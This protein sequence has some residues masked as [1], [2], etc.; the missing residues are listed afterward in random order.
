M[1]T[2][3][4]YFLLRINCAK[5]KSP[6][7]GQIEIKLRVLQVLNT[8]LCARSGAGWLIHIHPA[9]TGSSCSLLRQ[10]SLTTSYSISPGHIT[11]LHRTV[12]H[13]GGIVRRQQQAERPRGVVP[14]RRGAAH[15]PTLLPR[16]RPPR[17]G[18]VHHLQQLAGQRVDI[19]RAA[20]CRGKAGDDRCSCS[21]RRRRRRLRCPCRAYA[22][23]RGT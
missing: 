7:S 22:R 14:P 18:L 2:S 13:G 15:C 16:V 20:A 1:A 12:R 4:S 21:V 9:R 10:H 19:D 3:V 23:S 11:L 8:C 6:R 5:M 17:R